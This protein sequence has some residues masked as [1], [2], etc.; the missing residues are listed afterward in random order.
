MFESALVDVVQKAGL[1]LERGARRLAPL[2]SSL[3]ADYHA[4]VLGLRDYCAKS[5]FPRVL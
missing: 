3:E 4:M 2:P 5:G 1:G